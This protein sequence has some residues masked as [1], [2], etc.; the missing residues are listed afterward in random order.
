MNDIRWGIGPDTAKAW[1]YY[2]Q[3]ETSCHWYWDYDTANPWDGN[4]T[5]GANLAIAEANKVI[6]RHAGV[7]NV[8][9]SIFPPQRPIWNP[10][11]KHWTDSDVQP[12]DFGIW[13]FV[14]DASGVA[15]VRL[16][17]RTA[18]WDTWT[19][20]TQTAHELYAHT[21]GKNSPGTSNP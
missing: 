1:R 19:D 17:W 7:D 20:L 18:D 10:G 3:A 6:D 13:T 8:G 15:N 4:A 14:D 9:P 5:R 2:L 21:P 11:G 16:Y 12:S